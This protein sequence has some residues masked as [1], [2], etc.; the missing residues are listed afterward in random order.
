MKDKHNSHTPCNE[1]EQSN[2]ELDI[3]RNSEIG[4]SSQEPACKRTRGRARQEGEPAVCDGQRPLVYE[5]RQAA[6]SRHKRPC[7]TYR[8]GNRPKSLHGTSI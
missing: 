4:V 5:K 1:D 2:R 8:Q 6:D 7:P 3:D